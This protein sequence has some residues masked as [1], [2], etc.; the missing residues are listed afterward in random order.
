MNDNSLSVSDTPNCGIVI[1][2]DR[3]MFII[4]ATES[5]ELD[6]VNIIFAFDNSRSGANLQSAIIRY[7]FTSVLDI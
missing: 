6:S 4:Q 1:I 7:Q 2:Y 3:N 5:S